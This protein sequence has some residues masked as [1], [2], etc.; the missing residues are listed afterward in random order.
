MAFI[1]SN[2]PVNISQIIHSSND[3]IHSQIV[4]TFGSFV[5]GS[6]KACFETTSGLESVNVLWIL[7]TGMNEDKTVVMGLV[8]S[9]CLA[10][11]DEIVIDVV[12]RAGLLG[13]PVDEFL[14]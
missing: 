4:Q 8:V 14:L 3:L 9:C 10:T 13:I 12:G 2:S 11:S 5:S 6:S 1:Q 7:G